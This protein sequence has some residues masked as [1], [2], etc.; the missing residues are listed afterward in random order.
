MYPGSYPFVELE[1]ALARVAVEDPGSVLDELARDEQGLVRAIKR[2]LPEDTRL[3]L[4]ID[5]FEELFT[6]TREDE[7]RGRFL[8]ALVMLAQDER[9]DVRIVVTLRADFFD[10]PL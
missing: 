10:R 4:V 8:Q 1:S 7:A 5:Q 3:L 6:L 9:S 2:L